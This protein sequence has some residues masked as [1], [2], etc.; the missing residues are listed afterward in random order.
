MKVVTLPVLSVAVSGGRVYALLKESDGRLS[1]ASFNRELEV[2]DKLAALKGSRGFVLDAWRDSLLFSVDNKL[3]ALRG[4]EVKS[5]LRAHLPVNIFWHATRANGHV[6]VQ[7]YGE[8]PTG[9]FELDR[10]YESSRLLI[11]NRDLDKG[12]KH[13]H[14]VV[15]DPFRGWLVA[16]L[17]DGNLLRVA[18]SANGGENWRPLYRGPWQFVPIVPLKDTIVFGMDSGIARGGVGIYYPSKKRWRFIF[19][20]WINERVKLA[21]MSDLKLL[22]NGLWVAAL[23]TPQAIVVSKDLKTW[24]PLYVEGFDEHFNHYMQVSV[25]EDFIACSTGRSLLVFRKD[26]V[27]NAL[28]KSEPAMA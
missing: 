12:S 16:T 5:V 19:L 26:E 8:S 9:I 4:G 10:D 6:Y 23:G 20:K 1:L 18:V 3:Y 7:E 21:Q 17:G 15:Y 28:N 13:F 22:S 24:Y 11:T 2:E 25:G 14:S 27:Y